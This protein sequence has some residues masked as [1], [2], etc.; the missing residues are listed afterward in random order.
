MGAGHPKVPVA[1]NKSMP[2]AG[3]SQSV[4]G[5]GY[6]CAAAGMP[7]KELWPKDKSMLE[8]VHLE[9]SVALVKSMLQQVHGLKCHWLCARSCWSTS[10]HVAMD[11]PTTEQVQP[12]RDC[13]QGKAMLELITSEGTVAVGKATAGAGLWS[14]PMDKAVLEQVHLEVTVAVDESMPQQG[15]PWRDCGS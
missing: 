11:K 1:M 10:K 5:R 15:Y 3:I 9:A 6:V 12:W 7:L 4:C 13:S 8:T 14:W 2:R